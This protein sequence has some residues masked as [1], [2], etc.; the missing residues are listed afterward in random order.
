MVVLPS[1]TGDRR[2]S[3]RV[4]RCPRWPD[5]SWNSVRTRHGRKCLGMVR[6]L[7]RPELLQPEPEDESERSRLRRQSRPA[8]RR[9][10]D[11]QGLHALPQPRGP[12][13]R[14]HAHRL[15]LRQISLSSCHHENRYLIAIHCAAARW[16]DEGNHSACSGRHGLPP[17]I[18]LKHRNANAI[19]QA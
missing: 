11:E 13:P 19:F 18:W 7:A 4:R 8:R 2:A 5:T 9:L 10:V 17:I 14:L 16:V 1:M 15:S 12:E 3:V 6:G